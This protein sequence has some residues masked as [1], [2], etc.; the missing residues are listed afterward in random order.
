MLDRVGERN[1]WQML[2]ATEWT[3][4]CSNSPWPKRS[5]H[6]L[7]AWFLCQNLRLVHLVFGSAATWES[8]FPKSRSTANIHVTASECNRSGGF[9]A[10]SGLSDHARL[11]SYA[12]GRHD[13]ELIISESLGTKCGSPSRPVP[14]VLLLL[15]I[16]SP[17]F[18]VQLPF[19]PFRA[20][21]EAVPTVGLA[22]PGFEFSG[23][24]SLVSWMFR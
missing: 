12:F 19:A 13:G 1:V 22:T 11:S 17:V 9:A 20:E 3:E 6:G 14:S 23:S 15:L 2:R 16:P 8:A 10:S 18:P 21:S 24:D 7:S 5:A 4:A